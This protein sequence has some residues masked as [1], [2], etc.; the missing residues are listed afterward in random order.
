MF[1]VRP[2]SCMDLIVARITECATMAG[3][4]RDGS[5]VLI[6]RSAEIDGTQYIMVSH[7]PD[8]FVHI[9]YAAVSQS[10]I[11][12]SLSRQIRM[13]CK[14]ITLIMF[15]QNGQ[16]VNQCPGC[17]REQPTMTLC[18]SCR[19]RCDN[20]QRLDWLAIATIWHWKQANTVLFAELKALVL[21]FLYATASLGM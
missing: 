18:E 20:V 21:H 11:D 9:C 3:I 13:R 1:A 14:L 17:F 12:S 4:E 8:A 6:F 19:A 15:D 7:L 2:K 10:I 16:F 5:A